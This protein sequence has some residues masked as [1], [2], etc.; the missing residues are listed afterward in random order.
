MQLFKVKTKDGLLYI[1]MGHIQS[2]LEKPNGHAVVTFKP[3]TG[4]PEITV[5]NAQ[6][7]ISQLTMEITTNY[8]SVFEAIFGK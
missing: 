7:L 4:L 3:V 5:K 1:P 2:V 8:P 6:S